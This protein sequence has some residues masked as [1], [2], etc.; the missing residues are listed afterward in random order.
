MWDSDP[1]LVN[2]IPLILRKWLKDDKQLWYT[3]TKITAYMVLLCNVDTP[4]ARGRVCVPLPWTHKN[5]AEV[6]MIKGTEASTE[7]SWIAHTRKSQSLG[8][9][10]LRGT[11]LDKYWGLQ[12]TTSTN[13]SAMRMSHSGSGSSSL[14]RTP[15]EDSRANVQLQS[16]ERSQAT[17]A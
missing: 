3:P 2:W 16:H 4:P 1:I 5:M 9:R 17:T 10:T 12:L 13:L 15:D 8:M 7:V 11:H 6:T 14:V